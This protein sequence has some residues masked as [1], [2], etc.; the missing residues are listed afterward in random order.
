[1]EDI[2]KHSRAIEESWAYHNGCYVM[3]KDIALSPTTQGLN[4]GTGTFEGIQAYWDDGK[5]VLYILKLQEHFERFEQSCKI[6][7]I[8]LQHTIDDFCDITLNILRK[9]DY[10]QDVYIR[11]LA[12]KLA[13][14]SGTAVGVKL[15]G[16]T[17]AISIFPVPVKKG[18]SKVGVHCAVSSWQRI[19]DNCAP[20]RAKITGLYVNIALGVDE[21]QSAGYDDAI[22]LNQ[23]GTVAEASTSNIFLVRK[24][25][26]ITPPVS[27]GILEGITRSAIIEL[28]A[29]ELGLLVV[30]RD[31][32]RTELYQAEEIF[33]TGTAVQVTPVLA[34]D[35]RPVGSSKPGE[36]TTR[37]QALYQEA[38][39]GNNPSY[40][41]W[42][43]PVV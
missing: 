5:E 6:L 38:V 39:H 19:P 40:A 25:A 43:T 23:R 34:I 13:Y 30:E 2:L 12:Y 14:E 32:E 33:L 11:P 3:L 24:G 22:F 18:G 1:M 17:A 9:N 35:Q 29:R 4:Y 41:H 21:V 28:A 42:I 36:I 16:L 31:V 27:A 37:L 10:R 26:L 8:N 20:V 15:S 7:R